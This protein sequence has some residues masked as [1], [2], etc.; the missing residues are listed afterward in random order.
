P[1]QPRGSLRD[2]LRDADVFIGLSVGNVLK[3][4]D[5]E[6]MA[7]ARIVFA[8]ANPDPEVSPELAVS[9]CRIFATGRSD[10]PNQINNA[11]AFPG[12]FRGALDVQANQINEAMKLAAARAIADGI[13]AAEANEEY[14][15]PSVLNRGVA[16]QVAGSVAAAAHRS[17]VARRRSG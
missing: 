9:H 2:A 13:S 14:I 4:E 17:G 8:M 16:R 5:L 12:I 7:R 10:F 6:L 15:V 1:H 3:A 11:L